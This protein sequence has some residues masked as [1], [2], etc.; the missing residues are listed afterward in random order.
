MKKVNYKKF[1]YFLFTAVLL[2]GIIIPVLIRHNE[3][4]FYY[5]N[6]E[7]LIDD[8]EIHELCSSPKTWLGLGS[9]LNLTSVMCKDDSG[10]C[11]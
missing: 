7:A 10:D 3:T 11:D 2:C 8:E 1:I 6:V 9:C 5:A 4:D